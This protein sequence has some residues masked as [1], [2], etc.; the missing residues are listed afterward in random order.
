MQSEFTRFFA[1]KQV[2]DF[3]IVRDFE[4]K[5]QEL[6]WIES[7]Q[8]FHMGRTTQEKQCLIYAC[9]RG[10]WL[11]PFHCYHQNFEFQFYS[12]DAA[13]GCSFDCV[14]CY[15]QSYLNH[16]ALVLF[17]NLNDLKEELRSC[18]QKN[19]W[20]STGLLTDSLVSE[21]YFPI[22]PEIS[23]L[24]PHGS[25]LELRTKSDDVQALSDS[26]IHRE[27]IVVSW[28]LNPSF[29]ANGYEYRAADLASRLKA[30]N[31]AMEMGYR[32]GFHL[33]PVFYFD[34]WQNAYRE[35]VDRI[36]QFPKEK[37][38]F[39]SVGLFR[40]MP[41]LGSVIRKRFPMHPILAGEFLADEDGKYHYFRE[42]RKEMHREFSSW[43]EPWKPEVPVFWSMEP[44]ERIL[45]SNPAEASLRNS[46]A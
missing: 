9:K 22:L 21:K 3:P 24:L 15:L 31:Q 26:S 38:A 12:L 6:Q 44:D 19:L 29:I 28:S 33:D 34:G 10:P 23:P 25:V 11:K 5:H 2:R 37:I 7:Y 35:L 17:V 40:Y 43:L 42:I 8:Q 4:A 18:Q 27:Q 36:R 1:E 13:E 14:Y 45:R 30:A 46:T 41:D 16:G 20:I 32:L 39:L